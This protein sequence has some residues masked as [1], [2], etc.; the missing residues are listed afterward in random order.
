MKNRAMKLNHRDLIE[1]IK[2]TPLVAIDLIIKNNLNEVLLGLRNNEPAK[3]FWFVPGGRILIRERISDSFQ[4]IVR[5]E[6]GTNLS[7]NDA[8]F[9]GVFEHFY[10]ENFANESGVGTH[11]VVLAYEVNIN[12]P[13][14]ELPNDQHYTYKWLK[15][16]SLLKEDEVH[17]NTK[18]YFIQSALQS[19]V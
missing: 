17:P 3:N 5:E 16:E 13:L 9:L 11:Y 8:T 4:R 18:A 10:E 15:I 19:D 1:V 2:K 12:G 6:L 14:N 7:F